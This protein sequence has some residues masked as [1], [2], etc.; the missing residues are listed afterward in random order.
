M[1]RDASNPRKTALAILLL[2]LAGALA[3]ALVS[4]GNPGNM[5]ICGACFL[6]DWAG[7]LGL[8]GAKA[9]A[10]LRP[11]LVGLLLGALLWSLR[12]GFVARSGSHAAARFFLGAW[13]GLGALVFLG[14]PFRLLQRLGGG[15]LNAWIALPGFVLGVGAALFLEKRGYSVGK[16]SPVPAPVG[17]LGP[18][19]AVGLLALFLTDPAKP[20][21]AP[22]TLSLGLSWLVGMILSATGF[23]AISAARRVFQPGKAMLYAAL[24][25]VAG[26][27]ALSFL[28]GRLNPSLSGQPTAHADHLWSLAAIGL[29]G[30]CGALAGGCPVRQVVMAGEGNGDAFVTAAGILAGGALAHTLGAAAAPAT[31]EAIGGVGPAGQA[32]VVLGWILCAGYG[33]ARARTRFDFTSASG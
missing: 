30:F 14:C 17:L 20:P 2:A 27:A 32:A 12:K 18:L 16:T 6:R 3:A 29:V 19:A 1:L 4:S 28:T 21:H 24:A 25:F 26:Y 10:Y 15:D 22:W 5:G 13:M 9:P 8:A 23:C 31:A 11:E 7:G 33:L